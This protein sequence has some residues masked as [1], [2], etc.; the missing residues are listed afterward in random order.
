MKTTTRREGENIIIITVP[1]EEAQCLRVALQPCMCKHTKS[2]GT[3]EL[4][5]RFVKGIGMAMD[6]SKRRSPAVQ[7]ATTAQEAQA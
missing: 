2:A 3:A 5:A 1:I 7:A 6:H 4:R